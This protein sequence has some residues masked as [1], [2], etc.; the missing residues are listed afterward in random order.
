LEVA[1]KRIVFCFDGTWNALNAN[2]PTNVVLTA[3]SIDRNANGISQIIHY[4]EGVGTGRLEKYSG[5]MFGE[6]LI[7]N[8][9]EAY[10]FLIFN[11][12][13]G[14]EIFVFGFSRG[15]FSAQTFVGFV[16]HVG[17]LRR[18]HAGHIDEALD[19]YRQR[20]TTAEGSSERVRRFRAEY[21]SN[22]CIGEDDEWRS[23]NIANYVS[24]SVPVLTIKYLGLWDTVAAMGV[25][26]SFPM[27]SILNKKYQFH[28]AS[29]S[30][31][32]QSAR[33]AVA[34]D[35]RRVL[36]PP[37]LWGDLTD[38][39]KSKGFSPED[40]DAPYQER[41]FPGVHGSVGGGG[42]IRGL[43]DGS[44]AWVLTGAKRAGLKLDSAAGSRI[45]SVAPDHRAPLVNAKKP[46]RKITSLLST[47]RSGPEHFFQLSSAVLH[48]WKAA[49]NQL[50]ENVA[51][52][53]KALSRVTHALDSFQIPTGISETTE[54]LTKHVVV[55]GDLLSKLAHRYYGD[56]EKYNF[57]FDANRDTIDDPDELYI[58]WTIRIPKLEF[59]ATL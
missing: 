13:P 11:Y 55:E 26:A 59:S 36:F 27:S 57:I 53:P 2:T 42:D 15:A 47:D 34:T 41:W 43:S 16:R 10:R 48:R 21:S 31:F 24:G 25:P 40:K 32:I 38:I 28:D 52:R 8:V 18:L 17:P 29:L 5:G 54:I 35:E 37:V 30:A 44:L 51:Y 6:G 22:V 58:G 12:D 33:H 50:P 56:A 3:A 9:R 39:N 7:E 46:K 1:L 19:L 20:L 45:Q 23:K 14:D 49:P 4:D